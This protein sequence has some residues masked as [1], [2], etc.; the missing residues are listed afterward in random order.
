MIAKLENLGPFQWF[1]TLSC[2]DKKWD[3][4]FS[5]LLAETDVT[6][7]YEVLPD[8]SSLT[9]VK[10]NEDGHERTLELHEYIAN[11]VD[12]SLHEILRTNV[13]NA[14]R[15]FNHRVLEKITQ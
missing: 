8:G 1:F 5:S 7:E 6:L 15:N 11:K 14:T 4:N 9:I 13:L 3:E 2:A 10:F 12:E